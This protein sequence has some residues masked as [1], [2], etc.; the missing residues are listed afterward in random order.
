MQAAARSSPQLTQS[1]LFLQLPLTPYSCHVHVLPIQRDCHGHTQATSGQLTP[2]MR[3]MSV[4]VDHDPRVQAPLN[5]LRWPTAAQQPLLAAPLSDKGNMYS[6]MCIRSSAASLLPVASCCDSHCG[7]LDGADLE[8]SSVA[9]LPPVYMLTPVVSDAV[10]TWVQ[11]SSSPVQQRSAH[12]LRDGTAYLKAALPSSRPR[13]SSTSLHAVSLPHIPMSA[14][15]VVAAVFPRL[16]VAS[17]PL[18][19]VSPLMSLPGPMA[20]STFRMRWCSADRSR[21]WRPGPSSSCSPV[22]MM[23]SGDTSAFR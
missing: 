23:A 7:T 20:F 13:V 17:M 10:P 11:S 1:T 16:L 12:M 3:S 5:A 18:A 4:I 21:K 2:I 14:S 22:Q 19:L 15:F 6:S 8:A 9:S